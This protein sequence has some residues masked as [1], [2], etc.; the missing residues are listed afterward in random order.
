MD[1]NP[2][3]IN[4]GDAFSPRNLPDAAEPWGRGVEDRIIALE[5]AILGLKNSV[6]GINRNVA[7]TVENTR[8]VL[9]SQVRV[10]NVSIGDNTQGVTISSTTGR[11]EV[12]TFWCTPSV[13]IPE[14]YNSVHIS[15]T[16][17]LATYTYTP[18]IARWGYMVPLRYRI[19]GGVPVPFGPNTF[20]STVPYPVNDSRVATGTITVDISDFHGGTLEVG[21][22]SD[23]LQTPPPDSD[24][25]V[26]VA[27]TCTAQL[28]FVK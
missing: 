28:M 15:A 21:F 10:E 17:V 19:N 5:K 3:N 9:G 2:Q 8:E 26:P 16:G 25:F 22:A 12:L 23:L 20:L 1:R 6:Q 27:V 13:T 11:S 7:A 18:A 14:G 4:P 24:T